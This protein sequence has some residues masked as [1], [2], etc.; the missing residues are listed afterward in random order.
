MPPSLYNK[1]IGSGKG[2]GM[3]LSSVLRETARVYRANLVQGALC[4]LLQLVLRLIVAAPLLALAAKEIRW[5]ALASIP[6]YFLIIPVAR[7]NMAQ[8]MQTAIGAGPL[9]SLQ[10]ISWENYGLKFRRGLKQALVLLIWAV[11]FIAATGVVLWAYAGRIDAFTLLRVL[12]DLGG[13]STMEGVKRVLLIYA[14]TLLPIVIGCAFHS[15]TRHAWALG[16]KKLLRG[17]RLGL[18]KTWF[19]GLVGLVPFFAVVGVVCAG[20]VS[21]LVSALSNFATGGLELPSIGTNV[22]IILA[23]FVLLFLPMLAFKQLMT[24]VHVHG[25]KEKKA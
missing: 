23:A 17:H 20:F 8:A 9:F 4:V 18:M 5:V 16:D 15:G 14:A 22:Y 25:L 10:L 3:K 7:Q 1:M 21:A 24:A 13:G 19:A 11:L 6:L 2:Y 12:M